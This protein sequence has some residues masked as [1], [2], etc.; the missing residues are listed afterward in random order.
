MRILVTGGGSGGHITPVLA[1]A[2]ELKRLRP[3]AQVTYVGQT[4]DSL[5]DIP[6]QDASIDRVVTVRAGKFRRYHGEG[7][8]QFLDVVTL[9][10]NLRDAVWLLIG[11]W[12]SFWLLVRERP[13]VIFTRGSFVSVP[14]CLAA[15][16]RGIPFITHDSDAIP[17]LTNRLIG[18]WARVNAVAL[19]KDIYPY[20]PQKT[21]TVGVPISYK[22]HLLK[23]AEVTALRERLHLAGAEQVVLMTGG[24]LG[25]VRI[26]EAVLA[27]ASD[28]LARYP[29]LHLVHIAGRLDEDRVRQQY[30]QVLPSK[31]QSRVTVKGFVVNLYEY[32]GVADVIITR[33]GGNAMAEF[34]A[35]AKPCLKNAQV[36]AA[37]KA[38]RVVGEDVLAEDRHALMP[39]L[40]DF[41]DHPDKAASFGR[42][43]ASLAQPNATHLLAMVLLEVVEGPLPKQPVSKTK[44]HADNNSDTSASSRSN[45]PR[46]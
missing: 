11:T 38:V 46:S 2:H 6:E 41:L 27:C 16:L 5:V 31:Q 3:D 20:P 21:V 22:F 14:V 4:G 29:K 8:K 34:A 25:A 39:A 18:R 28:L 33:A 42:K 26:N 1:V 24:G 36:L 12:Q 30:K 15:K 19:P 35:Q 7:L 45:A 32:S 10:K 40:T 23:P 17:S 13:D 44:T 43:L 37:R 9:Y